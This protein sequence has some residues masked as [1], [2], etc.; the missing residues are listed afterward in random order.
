MFGSAAKGQMEQF[1]DIDMAVKG[2]PPTIFFHAM[3]QASKV[4]DCPLDLIDLDEKTPFIR[5]L[6]E[7]GELVSVG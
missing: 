1:S 5:Y 6:I 3:G 7:E 2:L 4:L